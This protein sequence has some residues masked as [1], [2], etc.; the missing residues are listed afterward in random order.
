MMTNKKSH[1]EVLRIVLTPLTF[2]NN[3][4]TCLTTKQ[5]IE[6]NSDAFQANSQYFQN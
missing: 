3:L 4:W 5:N 1:L 6:S 2:E